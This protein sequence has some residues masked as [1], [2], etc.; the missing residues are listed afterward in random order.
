MNLLATFADIS[1]KDMPLREDVRLLGRILGDTLREQE[2]DETFDLVENVRRC[3]VLFRKTQDE[4]DRNQLE[5]ILN[6]LSPR[7]TLSVVRAFSYF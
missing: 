4:R 5:K 3:A 1:F 7:D 2:G 6:A